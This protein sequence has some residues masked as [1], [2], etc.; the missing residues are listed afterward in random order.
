MK[1]KPNFLKVYSLVQ[2]STWGQTHTHHFISIYIFRIKKV[3]CK[4]TNFI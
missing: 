2:K 3:V 4:W 1:F